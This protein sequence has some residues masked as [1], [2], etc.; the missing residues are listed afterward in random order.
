M[1]RKKKEHA[2]RKNDQQQ[3]PEE[4]LPDRDELLA[5]LK[6]V[7]ADYMNYQKR[8]QKDITAARE[9]ANE[10]LIKDLLVVLDDMERAMD[11]AL[12]NHSKDDPLL[13]G[14]QLVHDKAIGTLERFGL[15]VIDAVGKPFDP[16]KHSAMMQEP[17]DEHPP[18]TVIK[19]ALKGY[20]LKGRTIRPASVVVSK[21]AEDEPERQDNTQQ[22]D[23]KSQS[24]ESRQG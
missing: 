3:V 18:Q 15:T 12:A 9:F 4:S 17:S 20:Q 24:D 11:A 19:Q 2:D 14:M 5:R 23:E 1:G 16:Q 21:A 6:R 10:Q 13:M 8:I 7:S 22:D